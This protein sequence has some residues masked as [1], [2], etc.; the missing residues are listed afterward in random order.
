[1]L[2]GDLQILDYDLG[3]MDT[4]TPQIKEDIEFQIGSVVKL[5]P[6]KFSCL[7]TGSYS[8]IWTHETNT[9]RPQ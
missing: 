8:S 7:E 2:H 1:V 6:V 9:P 5:N 4:L 3:G